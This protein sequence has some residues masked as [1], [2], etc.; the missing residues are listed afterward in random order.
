MCRAK[1]LRVGEV[2]RIGVD[3]ATGLVELAVTPKS[4]VSPPPWLGL[5][6]P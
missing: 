6:E 2:N 5:L 1:V 3:D 4:V